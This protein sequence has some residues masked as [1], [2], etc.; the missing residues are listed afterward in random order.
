[1]GPNLMLA[2][3]DGKVSVSGVPATVKV[4][5]GV[6]FLLNWSSVDALLT[7]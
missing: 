3:E 1:M 2:G 7:Q 6:R 5:E 4:L